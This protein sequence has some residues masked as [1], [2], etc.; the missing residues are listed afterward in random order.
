MK[1]ALS[2]DEL[3]ERDHAIEIFELLCS[4]YEGAKIFTF[5]HSKGGIIGPIEMRKISS[6]YLSLKIKN[7]KGFKK[8][9]FLAPFAGLQIPC[10]FDLVINLSRGLSHGINRCGTTRQVT[11]LYDLASLD[12]T[13]LSGKIFYSYLKKWSLEKLNSCDELILSSDSMGKKLGIKNAKAIHPFVKVE[14][15]SIINSSYFKHDFFVISTEGLSLKKAKE[16]SIFLNEHKIRYC[17][18]GPDDLLKKDFDSSI[19]MGEKCNGELAPLLASAK[20]LIH[21]G[22]NV[23]PKNAISSLLVGRPVYSLDSE[24]NREFLDKGIF[25]SDF[26]QLL[27]DYTFDPQNLRASVLK[28]HPMGFKGQFLKILEKENHAFKDSSP[29]CC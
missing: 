24:Y 27:K 17:F 2:I 21:L 25:F 5:V 3:I 6:T 16:V 1:I 22:E 10:G 12:K 18:V 19:L 28:F 26:S 15:F 20:G 14:D 4:L 13:T 29:S 23:F 11:Y 9:S 7:K 8:L